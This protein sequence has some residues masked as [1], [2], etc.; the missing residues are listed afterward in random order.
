MK[1]FRLLFLVPLASSLLLGCSLFNKEEKKDDPGQHEKDEKKDFTGLS[2]NNGSVT[3]DGEEHTLQLQGELPAGA[4]QT[5]VD[6]YEGGTLPGEYTIKIL[7]QCDGYND[8]EYTAILTITPAQFGVL[9]FEGATV[10]YDGE[11]HTLE[12]TGELPTGAEIVYTVDEDEFE[13]ASA[14][15][16]YDITATVSLTGYADAVLNATLTIE[17]NDPATA[18]LDI[19]DFEDLTNN[20]LNSEWELKY[21]GSSGWVDPQAAT[22]SIDKNQVIPG[23]EKTMKMSLTQQGAAFKATRALGDMKTFEKYAGFSLDTYVKPFA[24]GSNTKLQVQFWFKDLPLPEAYAGYKNTYATFTLDAEA[25]H[26]WAHWDI[27]FTDDTLSIAGGAVP[28]Q[29]ITALGYTFADFTMYLDAVAIIAT[30]NYIDGKNINVNIDNIKLLHEAPASRANEYFIGAG[31]YGN[32][33]GENYLAFNIDKDMENGSFLVDGVKQ[34]DLEIEKTK[35]GLICRDATTHGNGLEVT[36]DIVGSALKITNVSGA[37]QST[38]AYLNNL[39]FEKHANI[40]IDFTDQAS[41]VSG[42]LHDDNWYQEKWDQTWQKVTDQMNVRGTAGDPHVNMVTG[43]YMDYRYTYTNAEKFG[44]ANSFSM[45][46]GNDFASGSYDIKLK[47][48]LIKASGAEVY[49]VGSSSEYY[50]VPANTAKW[51]TLKFKLDDPIEVSAIQVVVKST[52]GYNQYLYVDNVKLSYA[53]PE[54]T[55]EIHELTDGTFYIWNAANDAYRIDISDSLANATVTKY[56]S[57]DS[58]PMAVTVD[59]NNITIADKVAAGAGLTIVGEIGENEQI[60]ISN[61]TGAMASE[62]SAS[63]IGKTAKK[64]AEV[65][66]D[67]ADGTVDATYTE[68]HW[69]ESKYENSGWTAYA[70]PTD[71]RSK[72]DK[73]GNKVVNMHCGTGAKNFRYVPDLPIGPVNHL[74]VDLGNYWSSSAGT[75]RYKISLLDENDQVKKYVAGGDGSNWATLDKDTSKGNLCVKQEFDFDLTFAKRLR[76]TTNMASGEAY[77]YMDNLKVSYK[78]P[79]PVV[80]AK[81]IEDG[82]YYIW[83]GN[84]DAFRM[85]VSGSQTAAVVTKLGGDSYAMTVEVNGETVTFKDAGYAGAGLTITATISATN[86]MTITNVTGQMAS[87][88][89]GSLMNKVIRHCA[90]MDLDFED[91]A[92]S[93]AYQGAGWSEQK[94]TTSW[95]NVENVEMNSRADD[96]GSKIVN[97]VAS[98]VTRNFIYDVDLP[99]GPVNHIDIDLGNFHSASATDVISYKIMIIDKGGTKYYAAGADGNDG[100]VTMSRDTANGSYLKHFSLDFNLCVGDKLQITTKTSANNASYFYVDNIHVSYRAASETVAYKLVDTTGWDITQ[101]SP[102]FY[103]WVW[104]GNDAGHWEALTLKTDDGNYF[105]LSLFKGYTG[106]KIVR[107]NPES[108]KKPIVGSTKYG[109]YASEQVWNETANID[110]NGAGGNVN[111]SF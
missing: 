94:Y 38:F 35:T 42:K 39:V 18:D 1:K 98:N 34:S 46:I 102:E 96:N 88:M 87:M 53:M 4:T 14:V 43:Y 44:L 91:G 31:T 105:D 23:G 13:G 78:A 111:F 74:E 26:G 62:F 110:L 40:N 100:F 85:E 29:A 17:A 7:V 67:F 70:T 5:Y 49:A 2:L 104:G 36:A 16:S 79:E 21:Y 57:T 68:S 10:H 8:K 55:P 81:T 80:P 51:Q 71:M 93:G 54:V 20:D 60:A 41:Y 92:G 76:I 58:Y 95:V 84:T 90:N 25:P 32:A 73:N 72:A 48:K 86:E 19:E 6:G 63:L 75:L 106:M 12:V 37:Y 65:S 47:V 64:S 15:G 9:T 50:V 33:Q 11:V 83:N 24:D 69:K 99:L 22:L 89:S 30:P 3:Y 101:A 82:S 61:V 109:T 52:G 107:V 108:T 27:P 103:A 28:V 45:D 66:L 97:L 56:G 77:L 59:G